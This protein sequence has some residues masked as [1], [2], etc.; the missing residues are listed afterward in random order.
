MTTPMPPR[1][2]RADLLA[3]A[4]AADVLDP[5][6]TRPAGRPARPGAPRP[7]MATAA[8]APP[9]RHRAPA[10]PDQ[11]LVRWALLLAAAAVI[12]ALWALMIAADAHTLA[13]IAS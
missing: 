12:L 5:P 4:R 10:A 9:A 1:T 7:R 2:P 3:V 6:R 8:A 13:G 11:R